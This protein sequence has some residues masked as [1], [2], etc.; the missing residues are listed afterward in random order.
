MQIAML[1]YQAGMR[2]E[3][4]QKG[5]GTLKEDSGRPEKLPDARKCFLVSSCRPLFPSS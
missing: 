3:A 4:P 2:N 5:R 1:L